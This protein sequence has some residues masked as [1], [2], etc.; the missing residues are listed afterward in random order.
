MQLSRKILI[1]FLTFGVALSAQEF[2]ASL[3]GKVTDPTGAAVSG[4]SI[5]ARSNATGAVTP[6]ITNDE[7]YYQILFLNPGDYSVSAE[8]SGFQ[9]SIQENLNL[10]VAEKATLDI[11]LSIGDVAQTMTVEANAGVVEAETADRG[12][13]VDAKRVEATPLQGRNIIA[14][15]WTSPGVAVTA[16]VQ[17]LRPFDIGGSGGMSINGGRPQMNEV[18][19]DGVTA[20][21]RTYSLTFVPQ[22]ETTDE[23]RVQTT[24][25]DAQY[26]GTTGGIINITTKSGSNAWHGSLFE[27]FQNTVL[28]ANTHNSNRNGVSRQSSN[29]NTFGGSV[30][31]AVIKNKLFFFFGHEQIRQAIPDPFSASVPTA[32]QRTGDFSK[33]YLPDGQQQTIYNPFTTRLEGSSFIRDPFPG[34]RIPTSM[35][36][37]VAANVLALVPLGNVAGNSVTGLN[38]LTNAGNTRKFVDIY[39]EYSGRGDYNFSDDTRMFIRYSRNALQETRGYRYST[40]SE[41]N[42]ADVTGNSPFTRDN[43]N[44][45]VQIT[46]TLNPTTILDIRGGLARFQSKGGFSGATNFDLSQ[47]GFSS[48]YKSQSADVFPRFNWDGY[49]GAGAEPVNTDPISQTTSAQASIYKIAGRHSLKTGGEWRLVRNNSQNPGHH[50]GNFTFSSLLTGSNPQAPNSTTGNSVASFLLGAATSGYVDVNTQPARQQHMF[51]YYFHDDFRVTDKLKVNMGL[52]WDLRGPITERFNS[53]LRGMDKDTP[54]PLQVPGL[55]L[56]GGPIYAGVNGVP[57]GAYRTDFNNFAPRLGFAYRLNDK[58]VFRGGYGLM[59]AQTFDEAPTAFGFSQSTS[60][61]TSVQTGIPE[62]LINNPFPGGLLQ[63]VGSSLGLASGLG[64]PFSYAATDRELPFTHQF[65]FEI[66]RELPGRFL[67]TAGY[68][69]NRVRGLAVSRQVNEISLESMDLGATYLGQSVPNPMAGKVPGTFLNAPT[70]LRSQLLRPFPQFGSITELYR[71]EG[72]SRYDG[73]QF[74]IS[75][76][77][78]GGLSAS[79]AYTYSR[80]LEQMNY[81]NAQDTQLEKTVAAWD[82]PQ[83]LQLNAVYELPFGQGKKLFSETPTVVKHLISGWSISGI[84]RLQ[85]GMP[86]GLNANSVP[87]GNSPAYSGQS[88]DR[89][90]NTCT[91]SYRQVNNEMVPVRSRCASD[92]EP[93]A[94]TAR[95]PN[96]L[97]TW[98]SNMTSVRQPGIRNLDISLMK[99]TQIYE[100][101]TLTFRA[102]ALN[103]TNTPQ[104]YNRVNGDVNNGNFGRIIGTGDQT[105]LPRFFQL[106]LKLQ[107]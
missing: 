15:A 56:R 24:V 14:L 36:N 74:M 46:H 45:V 81:R 72:K 100:R 86:I 22:S 9:K 3:A 28:N 66:Q 101:A 90:F 102:E 57:R 8:K 55:D 41:L 60:M 29:I 91:L 96:T 88:L 40:T 54:S 92:D 19:V 20:L 82:V 107:F 35:I 67:V 65:S 103:A 79:V 62:N 51:S 32:L 1:S 38:N 48:L 106:S 33:T 42:V 2:R 71:N 87:T 34:N 83:S 75:R 49:A 99:R 50:A 39:P 59:Y 27:Y 89:W 30:G 98:S 78:S 52:R 47:L 11:K 5:A 37:P 77:M 12:L 95:Q 18:L 21:G 43:H 76:R 58:T 104:W 13:T 69:G 94:W 73:F 17:R 6:A 63:P 105:N 85:S 44:A 25:Y 23:M 61:I 31:G 70:V 7:G 97:N 16:G 80:T 64:L 68:V 10:Q 26:G 53:I 84:A 93:V 4:A